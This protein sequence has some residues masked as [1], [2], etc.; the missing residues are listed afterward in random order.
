MGKHH[1]KAYWAKYYALKAK[2]NLEFDN[3]DSEMYDRLTRES[4][5]IKRG[6]CITRQGETWRKMGPDFF[7]PT[8]SYKYTHGKRENYTLTADIKEEYH[9]FSK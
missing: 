3:P 9:G 5:Y 8:G 2:S 7:N 4:S 1:S 6:K